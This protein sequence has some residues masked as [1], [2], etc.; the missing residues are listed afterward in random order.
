MFHVGGDTGEGL[1]SCRQA[2]QD[3]AEHYVPTCVCWELTLGTSTTVKRAN[4]R[5]APGK[6]SVWNTT[7]KTW[8]HNG[9]IEKQMMAFE[10]RCYIQ[11]LGITWRRRIANEAE[12]EK[13]RDLIGDY[14]PLLEVAR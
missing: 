13:I 1:Y 10:M 11:L 12:K 5:A 6:P 7:F 3:P 8:T 2:E 14:E 4:R 9:K